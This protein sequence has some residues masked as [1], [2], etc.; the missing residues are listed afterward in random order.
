MGANI[1]LMLKA[2]TH[3][4]SVRLFLLLSLIDASARW[5]QSASMSDNKRNKNLHSTPLVCKAGLKDFNI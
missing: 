2:A 4:L 1:N 3:E 5:R